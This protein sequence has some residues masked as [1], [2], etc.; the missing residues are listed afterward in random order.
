MRVVSRAAVGA[1]SVTD[2]PVRPAPDRPRQRG[3][4]RQRLFL[5]TFAAL[6]GIALGGGLYYFAVPRDF[7]WGVAQAVLL[8]HIASGVLALAVLVPFVVAHH[9]YQEGR[10]RFLLAP[11]LIRRRHGT[12]EGLSCARRLVGHAL[13]WSIVVVIASGVFVALPGILFYAGVVWLLGYE[14][15]QVGNAIHLGFSLL[16][17]GLIVLHWH[18]LRRSDNGAERS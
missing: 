1:M 11:W 14:A 10:S 12:R 15:Y 2:P 16:A 9:R 3:R 17:V 8:L 5:G 13:H 7:H 18:R 4:R 6:F